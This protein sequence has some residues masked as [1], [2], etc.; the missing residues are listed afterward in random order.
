[1]LAWQKARKWQEQ[2]SPIPFE[3]RVVWHLANG[4]VHSDPS[5]LVL[6]SLVSWDPSL[7]APATPEKPLNAW[8]VELASLSGAPLYRINQALPHPMEWI[9]FRRNNGPKIHAYQWDRFWRSVLK[10]HL[11]ITSTT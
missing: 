1:M 10:M 7:K 3:E 9:L 5:C 6:A 4:V 2:H 8:F 11:N